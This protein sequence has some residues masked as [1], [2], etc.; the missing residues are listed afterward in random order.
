MTNSRNI[1]KFSLVQELKNPQDD[2][3]ADGLR[4]TKHN[5]K[6]NNLIG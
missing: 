2:L 4:V 6:I 5:D 1:V 3:N